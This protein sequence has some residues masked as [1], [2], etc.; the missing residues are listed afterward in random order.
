MAGIRATHK[1]IR[2]SD[3]RIAAVGQGRARSG[4]LQRR[5]HVP[6]TRSG[7]RCGPGGFRD[8]AVGNGDALWPAFAQRSRGTQRDQP[9]AGALSGE[10]IGQ[11]YPPASVRIRQSDRNIEGL[12]TQHG[13]LRPNAGSSAEVVRGAGPR[14]LDADSRRACAQTRHDGRTSAAAAQAAD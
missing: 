4:G 2:G 9:R 3:L 12:F 11:S 5:H 7:R 1:S 14:R 13:A 10:H 6:E 8:L